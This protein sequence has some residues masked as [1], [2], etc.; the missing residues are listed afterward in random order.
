MT[1]LS[2]ELL[3][4][5]VDGQLARAQ[6]R[7]VAKVLKQDDV[8][9]RRV[10]ALKEAHSRLEA[11]FEAI[12]AGEVNELSAAVPGRV[13]TKPRGHATRMLLLTALII[14]ASLVA[15]WFYGWKL[16]DG[17]FTLG[18]SSDAPPKQ[19]ER[20]LS[21][22]QDE[23][24]RAQAF[25]SR[26]TLEVGLD[27]Q[28]NRDLVAF[29]LAGA[30]G[31]TLKVPD[32]TPQGFTFIRGA[33]L[34]YGDKPLAQLLYLPE[35]GAPLALYA[36]A[37]DGRSDPDYTRIGPVGA[38]SWSEGE[39]AYLL[40]GSG[41]EDS[42]LRIAAKIENEPETEVSEPA[43]A[44]A[45]EPTPDAAVGASDASAAAA[46]PATQP[47]PSVS[48]SSPAAATAEQPETAEPP[49]VQAPAN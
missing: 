14:G 36:L 20:L 7:A 31:P 32:L 34:Q 5:Y 21:I 15:A 1:E 29:Q 27:S 13:E 39:I 33:L 42:L 22:W 24:A 25:V 30:I 16:P 35:K 38:V 28:G 18:G 2:D 46:V 8:I 11:A 17:H 43:Q 41:D 40:A 47:A 9:A 12:L 49:S 4:A 10:E 3:V 26:A 45:S 44:D 48:E 23:A 6:T 19:S 37:S